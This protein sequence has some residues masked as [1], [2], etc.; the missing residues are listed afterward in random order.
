MGLYNTPYS[1]DSLTLVA[2]YVNE[3]SPFDMEVAS[4]ITSQQRCTKPEMH[5]SM[6]VYY[7]HCYPKN[8]G[9]YKSKCCP[10]PSQQIR[11]MQTKFNTTL[12]Y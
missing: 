6:P 12:G 8:V 11:S 5:I 9:P 1:Y 3:T 10:I 4:E 7:W 2:V